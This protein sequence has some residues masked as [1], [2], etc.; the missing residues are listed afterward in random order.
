[1][2]NI[3]LKLFAS[4]QQYLPAGTTGRRT[5]HEVPE[6]ATAGT[7]LHA[8]GVPRESAHLIIVNGVQAEWD[9]PLCEGDTLSA[10]PPVAGG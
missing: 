10:F 4:L 3:T 1:M 2:P 9:S 7:V 5:P 8:L 6:G